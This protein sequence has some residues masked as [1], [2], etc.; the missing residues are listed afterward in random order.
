MLYLEDYLEMIEHLPQEF[1][2]RSTEI[3]ELDLSVQNNMDALEKR[4]RVLFGACR[5]ND[6][7]TD[8][9]NAEF[10]EIRRGYSK[11]LEDADEKVQI[12]NELHDLV[13]RYVRRLDTE[14]Y[15]FKCELEADNKGITEVLEKRSL[16]LDAPQTIVPTTPTSHQ[17]KDSRYRVRPEKRRDSWA[18]SVSS[19]TGN[20]NNRTSESGMVGCGGGGSTRSGEGRTLVAATAPLALS[21]TDLAIQAAVGRAVIESNTPGTY[22]LGHM[23]AG[24]AIAA[25]ASQ[26]IVATQQMQQGRRTASLKASYE[27]IHAGNAGVGVGISAAVLGPG[28][29]QLGRDLA[30]AAQQALQ[31]VQHHDSISSLPSV[32]S[33][34]THSHSHS[35][36]SSSSS[37]RRHKKKSS[38]GGSSTGSSSMIQSQQTLAS[39]VSRSS[40]PT[41]SVR[42]SGF[43]I[44]ASA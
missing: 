1:R 5:R 42:T 23:G 35:Q 43:I 2:D 32:A 36:G 8:Q 33:P 29:L 7:S 4:V 40:S 13:E 19:M 39:S 25:A 31:A 24:T 15:K 22:S 11:T 3:R 9:A 16:E 12:A 27:A 20:S 38:Y 26:A 41:Q 44:L 21:R 34:A 6:V 37:N 17:N 18:G 14:L 28:E 10:A 30:G